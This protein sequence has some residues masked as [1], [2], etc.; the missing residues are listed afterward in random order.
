MIPNFTRLENFFRRVEQFMVFRIPKL[1]INN[2]QNV[3]IRK[4]WTYSKGKIKK[5]DLFIIK[6]EKRKQNM[7]LLEEILD[8]ENLNKAYKHV[9]AN[10]GAQGVDGVTI[11]ET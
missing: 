10:K 2:S 3:L 7:E 8:K 9:K 5:D 6:K 4:V 11:D 1:G